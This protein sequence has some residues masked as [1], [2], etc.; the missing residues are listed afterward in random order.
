MLLLAFPHNTKQWSK[1]G[2]KR[3]GGSKSLPRTSLTSVL[4]HIAQSLFQLAWE[5][6]QG[7]KI[8]SL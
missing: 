4:G 1:E 8:H 3:S 5:C 7:W 6:V 2:W